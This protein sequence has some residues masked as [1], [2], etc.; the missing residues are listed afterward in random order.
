[1]FST[2]TP[3]AWLPK[4][5]ANAVKPS[6]SPMNENPFS[7]GFRDA[8]VPETASEWRAARRTPVAPP[9]TPVE[10]ELEVTQ[11]RLAEALSMNDDL[12]RRLSLAVSSI[13]ELQRILAEKV[14]FSRS[15]PSGALAKPQSKA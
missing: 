15:P 8:L 13:A 11:M 14:S 5:Y 12:R 2:A 9:G 6:W 1:M 3:P 10:A 7:S 4:P